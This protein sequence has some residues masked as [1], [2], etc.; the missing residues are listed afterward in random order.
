VRFPIELFVLTG[1]FV[2][3]LASGC[4]SLGTACN[5]MDAPSTTT[6]HLAGDLSV[7]GQY[8]LVVNDGQRNL[9]T[10]TFDVPAVD[11]VPSSCTSGSYLNTDLEGDAEAVTALVT[12]DTLVVTLFLDGDELTTETFTP[13]YAEDE[14]N[15]EGCG[16]RRLAEVE[17][18][19]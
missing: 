2:A 12:P 4:G 14:P 3:G 1:C 11:E 6:I 5:L 7:E 17:L 13:D 19:W 16:V 15:G 8:E 18:D 10:C 9:L